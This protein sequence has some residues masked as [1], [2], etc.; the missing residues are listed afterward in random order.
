MAD[1]KT[2]RERMATIAT[3]A[4]SLLDQSSE[5]KDEARAAELESQ[6]DKAMVDYDDIVVKVD[7]LA[8]ME[9]TELATAEAATAEETRE[10]EARRP[11]AA[12]VSSSTPAEMNYRT[13][14]WEYMKAGGVK[15]NMP[16]EAR[17]VLEKRVQDTITD[18]KGAYTV[19]EQLQNV[20]VKT[21]LAWGP[22][23]DP[24]V[25]TELVT[26]SGNPITLPTVDDTTKAVTQHTQ[27]TT[28]TDDAGV[29][30]VFGEK[31]MGAFAYNTEFIRVSKELVDDSILAMESF[32]GE[33]LGERLGRRANV[34]LST[35]DGTGD[36]N[37]IITATSAGKTTNAVGAVTWDEIMDFEHSID[38]AYRAGPKVRWMFND[39]TLADIRKLKDGDGRYLWAT[40]SVAN[41]MPDTVGGRVFSINQAMAS[42]GTGNKFM[43]FGDFSKYWV[44]KVGGIMIGVVHDKDFWPGWGIAGYLRLDGE[45]LDTGAVKHMKNA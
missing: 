7:R 42:Q 24:G 19:D 36:P 30:V 26:S 14:F 11:G 3:E 40:G 12:I 18:S 9:A 29:D 41:G 2:M 16:A 13:A 8:K 25:T 33:L 31:T 10:R 17:T 21:M 45:L 15:E 5:T 44:R 34:E 22:M 23:Y 43:L 4:R 32:I 28:L 38:P 27:G 39:T 37:G 35:G 1:L 6:H 20:V